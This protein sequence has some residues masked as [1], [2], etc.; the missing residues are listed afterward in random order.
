MGKHEKSERTG[1]YL[2]VALSVFTASVAIAYVTRIVL[3]SIVRLGND[4]ANLITSMLEGIV[5]SIAIAQVLNQLKRDEKLEQ[6]QNE[7]EEAR[8]ILEYNQ[9]FIQ[10]SNMTQVEQLLENQMEGDA[11]KKISPEQRQKCI[12]Y[13]VYLEGLAPLVREDVLKLDHIDDLMAYRFFLAVNNPLLQEDQLF[14]YPEYYLGCFQLYQLW[15]EYRL[16]KG[17]DILQSETPLDRLYIR[18][19]N[20]WDN[21]RKMAELIYRTDPYIYPAAFGNIQVASGAFPFCGVFDLNNIVLAIKNGKPAGLAVVC[22]GPNPEIDPEAH[23]KNNDSLP[24]SFRNVCIDYFNRIGEYSKDNVYIACLSVDPENRRAGI[25][26]S[27]LLYLFQQFPQ[28]S[29]TLDVVCGNPAEDLYKKLGFVEAEEHPGYS[30]DTEKPR[31]KTMI[32]KA[33]ADR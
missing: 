1:K 29:F 9:A 26:T 6:E 8:F 33:D 7:I 23:M 24:E 10:D 30:L 16:N 3:C 14:R 4:E 19:A 15:K 32:R 27:L 22:H 17:K 5:A 13:L 31:V 11:E 18:G 25:G 21:K 20:P 12:N 28:A 2:F